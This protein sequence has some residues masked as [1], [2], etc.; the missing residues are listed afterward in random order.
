[1]GNFP[2]PPGDHATAA[3]LPRVI[4]IRSMPFALAALAAL[5]PAQD[6]RQT[7]GGAL[8]P[9]QA[10][11]DVQHYRLAIRVDPEKRSIAGTLTMTAEVVAETSR[12]AL[13]L[14][15]A[16]EATR[17]TAR[18]RE[19]TGRRDGLRLFVD[20]AE[21][22]KVG[23]TL[24]VDVDY[25]G[26]PRVAPM[27]PWKGGFTWAETADGSPW[28]ATSCQGE[29]ADL[30]WPC[31]DHPSDEPET[32]DLFVT[33]PDGLVCASNGTLAGTRPVPGG[34]E[35]HWSIANPISNYTVALNIA[36]YEV[37]EDTYE[38]VDG[39]E[40]PVYF[41]VLPENRKKAEIFLPEFLDHLRHLETVCGP[42]PFRNEKYGI[43][44]TPHLGMEHQ[45]IIAYGNKYVRQAFDYDWLHH[46]E[47]SHE[48]WANLVTARDWKDMWI[49]EGI[50][51]YMQALYIERK[52]G[53]KAYHTEMQI[54]RRGLVNKV[55]VA[56]R[57]V[58]DSQG[59]Y[60]SGSGNDIYYK[61]SWIC[62]T[63]RFLL[64]DE[65]FF[66]VLRR[67]AYPEPELEKVTDGSQTRFSDTEE[68]RAIAERIAE[69]DLG[70][71]F[72]VYLRQPK[73][74]RLT[75]RVQDDLLVLAWETPEDLPFPM[76]VPVRIDGE[77]RRVEM[78]ER[79]EVEVQ[80]G[81]A[82]FEVDPDDWLLKRFRGTRS[83]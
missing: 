75:A 36:P 4:A 38:C 47:L 12:I 22:A 5:A 14:D 57:E 46:H 35:F 83:R 18:D 69:R 58:T 28:I 11:Y 42:Y 16:L 7:S 72:A 64:G 25:G 63:L 29:G 80:V 19:S 23:E 30:W 50:G 79:G 68:I 26:T 37:I 52:F 51:T 71:F 13:D 55:A 27:P 20:L 82:A 32:M 61:G 60:F 73:L 43:V 53:E 44:E 6:D 15:K 78:P 70:W 48:W 10:C 9:E 45:T 8:I 24:V 31:K 56:P 49:H 74:P 17:I 39:T 59:I 33:V 66:R 2:H 81:N 40:L 54:K 65:T 34:R 41:W 3:T 67:W 1:M 76:P 77:M 21:P 62:H